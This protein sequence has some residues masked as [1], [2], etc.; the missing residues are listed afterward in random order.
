MGLLGSCSVGKDFMVHA[1]LWAYDAARMCVCVRSP[2]SSPDTFTDEL[3]RVYVIRVCYICVP[4]AVVHRGHRATPAAS[5]A[6][7]DRASPLCPASQIRGLPIRCSQW[8][9]GHPVCE[10]RLCLARHA[11]FW[12]R[13]EG[14]ESSR[15]QRLRD[16]RRQLHVCVTLCLSSLWLVFACFP[17]SF[18]CVVGARRAYCL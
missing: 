1:W 15:A 7:S 6:V 12:V 4:M 10:F 16:T 5:W 11:R 14:R 13:V 17:P 8:Q 18:E 2:V 9:R 3:G